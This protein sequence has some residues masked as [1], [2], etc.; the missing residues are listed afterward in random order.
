MSERV[1]FGPFESEEREEEYLSHMRRG[2]IL[3]FE[4]SADLIGEAHEWLREVGWD[5]KYEPAIGTDL[6]VEGFLIL[7]P[8]SAA[9]PNRTFSE[10]VKESEL[11]K[12]KSSLAPK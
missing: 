6:G 7:G 3:H 1:F 5:D 4:N 8:K 2:N 11:A 9:Q 12:K 10:N